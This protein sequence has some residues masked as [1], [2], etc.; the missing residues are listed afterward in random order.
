MP[1]QPVY[2]LFML[3][4]G[5]YTILRMWDPWYLTSGV[6]SPFFAYSMN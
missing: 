6:R 5:D 1:R 4:D 2:C 3:H